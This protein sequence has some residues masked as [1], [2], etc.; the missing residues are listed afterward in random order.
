VVWVCDIDTHMNIQM[1]QD[2]TIQN[3]TVS[4]RHREHTLFII[5]EDAI[6]N[7]N[8]DPLQLTDEVKL[9]VGGKYF[10]VSRSLVYQHSESMIGRLVSDTWLRKDSDKTIFI[11][12]DGD[13]FGHVLNYMRYGSIELPA[14]LPK[15]MFQRELDFYQ[16]ESSDDCIHQESPIA[17]MKVLKNRV[18]EASL[19]H[20]MFVIAVNCYHQFM[21]AEIKEVKV[22][23]DIHDKQ[24]IHTPGY[25]GDYALEVLNYYLGK[26]YGL[27][28]FSARS[29]QSHLSKYILR[30]KEAN[31]T[32]PG[33]DQTI[34]MSMEVWGKRLGG[35][36]FEIH[37]RDL[38]P[39]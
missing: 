3:K 4:P 10:E 31:G 11:D 29:S 18:E 38:M 7:D 36:T 1:L 25:Y 35:E 21:M 16:L 33:S 5:M 23:I 2:L 27:E 17:T 12:R 14:S 13:M 9:N 26:F 30:V 32:A 37:A 15:S 34:S 20:D 24:L 19:H 28:A 39:H 22:Y 8:E 6:M